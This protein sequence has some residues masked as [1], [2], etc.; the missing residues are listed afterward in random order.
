MHIITG[1]TGFIGRNLTYFFKNQYINVLGVSRNP[2]GENEI[3]YEQVTINQCN[4]AKSIIHLA[5]KAHDLKKTAR[6]SDY[7]EVN[8]KLTKDLFDVFLASECNDFIFFSSVKAVTDKAVSIVTEKTKT[9]PISA[10]G[11]SKLQAEQYILSQK[12]PL[13]KRMFIIRPAMIHG[14]GNIGNLNLLYQVVK[15]GIPWPLGAFENKRSFCNIENVC[16]VVQQILER[17][18]IPSGIYNIA[19]DDALSTNELIELIAAA[20]NKKRRILFIPKKV[21]TVIA[22]LGDAIHLPLNS[23]RFDKLTEN[24]VVDNTK[25][26]VALQIVRMPMTLKEG[27]TKT[28]HSFNH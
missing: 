6:D 19:D 10:Y 9:N 8:T 23:E 20:S 14:P 5:G 7:F 21:V 11:Q 22:R 15:K 2:D 12:L 26:K 3:S 28:I 18:D 4:N 17:K 25:I 24:F 1:N 13:G 27:L 16:F